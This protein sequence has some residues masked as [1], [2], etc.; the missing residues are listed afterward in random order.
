MAAGSIVSEP[1]SMISLKKGRKD[2]TTTPVM[3]LVAR[4]FEVRD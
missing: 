4:R 2:R 1:E 3:A